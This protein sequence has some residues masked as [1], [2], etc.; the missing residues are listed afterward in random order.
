MDKPLNRDMDLRIYMVYLILPLTA[1]SLIK[2]LKILAPFS[3]IATALTTVS[4]L[5][6][7]Y[8]IFRAPLSI[9]NRE[10]VGTIQGTSSFF[11]TVLFAMEAIGVV[12][13]NRNIFLHAYFNTLT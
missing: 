6:I 4:L 1:I 8:F 13:T 11:G 5:I 10:P 3:S 12:S 9:V 2:N 7:S